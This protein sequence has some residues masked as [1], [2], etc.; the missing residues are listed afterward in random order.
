[1][2]DGPEE[3]LAA[4]LGNSLEQAVKEKTGSFGNLLTRG[5]AIRLLCQE[6]G[7]TTEKKLA[8]SE[9]RASM[10]PFSFSARVDR[11]FPVQQFPGGMMRTVRLHVSD[12]SGEATI[13]LWN[14][15]A[16]IV[17]C[18]L[19]SGDILECTGAYLR[20]GEISIGRNGSISCAGKSRASSVI[21]LKDG[22]C[23]VEGLV[24][25]VGKA[26]TYADR[27]TGEEKTMHPFSLCNGGACVRV[28]AWSLPEGACLPRQGEQV[29]LENATF[30]NGEL[31]L[32]AFSRIVAAAGS[33][34][35]GSAGKFLGATVDGSGAIISIGTE[36]FCM[37][38]GSAL[39]MLS[40]RAVPSGVGA[41]TLLA[42]KSRALEGKEAHYFSEGGK[43]ASIEFEG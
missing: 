38:I 36:K 37:P 23:N 25:Q 35:G 14:E 17:E 10:L 13:V 12:K 31:H 30:R 9:A 8:L 43:L 5:A 18:G 2:D 42:I 40:V 28:V 16:K 11:V 29:V 41:A 20:A 3:K 22:I 7:I 15:Q 1:M 34:R 33:G 21:G 24:G 6:N 39:A 19:F 26:R 27:K 4:L 32:N